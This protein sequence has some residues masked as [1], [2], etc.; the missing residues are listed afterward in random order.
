MAAPIYFL[1]GHVNPV[2][3]TTLAAVGLTYAH[4][5][6]PTH[7]RIDGRTP[8][9]GAG[10]I[11]GD[12]TGAPNGDLAFHPEVQTWLRRGE[13]DCVWVG[14]WNAS[15]PTPADL[16]RPRLLPGDA[17]TLGDGNAWRV[18]RVLPFTGEDGFQIDLP[19]YATRNAQ[20]Q[21]VNGEVLEEFA[22]A[23]RIAE[24]LFDGMIRAELGAAPR[25]TTEEALDLSVELLSI[26]YAIGPTEA[27]LM[28]L[29]TLDER[30]KD[31]CKA[32]ASW[33]KFEEWHQ[34]KSEGLNP[35]GS[36]G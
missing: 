30:L 18:P 29:F 16:A 7:G 15:A 24:R 10:T 6:V 1:D 5:T 27:G 23:K 8:S 22:A 36:T 9:G 4:A 34:K 20:G 3:A 13:D 25:L 32:A 21:W 12:I 31:V 26:N 19:C 33:R 2:T 17:V 35:A 14:V 28:R 11:L